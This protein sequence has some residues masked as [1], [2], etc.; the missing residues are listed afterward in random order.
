[1]KRFL[2]LYILSFPLCRPPP[3]PTC[4]TYTHTQHTGTGTHAYFQLSRTHTLYQKM[5][6]LFPQ[7]MKEQEVKESE[8]TVTTMNRTND[9][10]Q[11]ISLCVFVALLLS[12]SMR[13]THTRTHTLMRVCEYGKET[14]LWVEMEKKLLKYFSTF[15]ESYTHTHAHARALVCV[16]FI[17]K[18]S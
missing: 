13:G 1:M 5:C 16:Y 3:S 2:L 18:E 4:T 10:S 8:E 7:A 9:R 12:Q 14:V 6:T 17:V 15:G 11:S